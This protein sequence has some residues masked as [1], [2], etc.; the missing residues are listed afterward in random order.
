MRKHN[1]IHTLRRELQPL[2]LTGKVT[3]EFVHNG[4]SRGLHE[5]RCCRIDIIS[6]LKFI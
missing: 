5:E 2:E 6:E 1:Q 4:T 3:T